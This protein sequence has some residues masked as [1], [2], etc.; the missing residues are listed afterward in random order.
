M[1]GFDLSKVT[2]FT[3]RCAVD[4]FVF[5]GF[6]FLL[7]ID[8]YKR[9]GSSTSFIYITAMRFTCD[10]ARVIGKGNCAVVYHGVFYGNHGA[11]KRTKE[12]DLQFRS[13]GNSSVG[14]R[15]AVKRILLDYLNPKDREGAALRQ[16]NHPNVVKLLHAESDATF[17]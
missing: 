10:T 12:G 13:D 11:H 14:Q 17:R 3:V 8:L 4:C 16:L 15:V 1:V 9:I 5:F 6:K 2:Y 7:I